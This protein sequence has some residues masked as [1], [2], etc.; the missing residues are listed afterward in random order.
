MSKDK[1]TDATK[2]SISSTK[3]SGKTNKEIALTGVFIALSM[4]LSYLESLVPVSF[5]VPGIKLGLANLVTIVALYKLGLRDT[6]IISLGRILLSGVLFGN[7]MI[8]IYSLAGACLSI[9]VMVLVKKLKMFSATGV[10]ICGAIAH[11][12]GQILVAVITLENMNIMYYM[13]ILAIAGAVAGAV[14]GVLSGM[15]IRNIRM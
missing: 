1:K 14:I 12:F 9:L 4:I 3:N 2:N 15:I 8:I 13:I 5:A 6:I 11:N 10:S 7:M